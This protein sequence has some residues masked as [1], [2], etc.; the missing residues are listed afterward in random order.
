MKKIQN[1]LI[2][3]LELFLKKR[4]LGKG[5]Q[6][7]EIQARGTNKIFFSGSLIIKISDS[8]NALDWEWSVLNRI[9]SRAKVP[10]VIFYNKEKLGGKDKYI[11]VLQNVGR[12]LKE[13]WPAMKK[14]E[15]VKL[16][17]DVVSN[18][19]K[20]NGLLATDKKSQVNYCKT[21]IAAINKN[22][23]KAKKNPFVDKS[24]LESLIKVASSLN[25]VFANDHNVLIYNNLS[26]E[27]VMVRK[28]KFSGLVDFAEAIYAPKQLELF[29]LMFNKFFIHSQMRQGMDKRS[30]MEFTNLLLEKLMKKYPE[31]YRAAFSEQFYLCSLEN[32]FLML[33]QYNEKYYNHDEAQKFRKIYC[34]LPPLKKLF[35]K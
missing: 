10:K 2:T 15:K 22:Y 7:Q 32:Y 30:E 21:I 14:A 29:K 35:L 33:S 23:L 11:L 6:L 31:L 19:K 5:S 12:G 16:V 28:G 8:P 26:F 18:V 13:A 4:K 24:E 9:K 3:L 17:E 1:S 27:N 25:A 20:I 34:E